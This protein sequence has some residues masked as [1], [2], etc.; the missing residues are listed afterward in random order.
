MHI[1]FTK[2][3]KEQMR[4]RN[5]LEDEVISTIKYAEM[6]NK[7]NN[8]YYARKNIGRAIIE[9]VYIREKYI[10]VITVYPL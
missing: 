3:A 5:I 8:V 10:K 1:E 6:I 9:V 7:I 2:H 4:E